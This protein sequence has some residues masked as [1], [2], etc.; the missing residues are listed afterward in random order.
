MGSG[1]SDLSFGNYFK[2]VELFTPKT[3][4]GQANRTVRIN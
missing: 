2:V 4:L 3:L 1:K